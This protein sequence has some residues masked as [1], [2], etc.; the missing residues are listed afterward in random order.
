VEPG[1]EVF[2]KLFRRVV[3]TAHR[4]RTETHEIFRLL[5]DDDTSLAEN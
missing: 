1:G 5:A 4:L 2:D 3:R